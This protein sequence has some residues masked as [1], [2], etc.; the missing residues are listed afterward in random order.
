MRIPCAHV[1]P[2]SFASQ[3]FACIVFYDIFYDVYYSR[4]T[5]AVRFVTRNLFVGP[6]GTKSETLPPSLLHSGGLW[7]A[8]PFTSD[9]R[10]LTSW[11]WGLQL[12]GAIAAICSAVVFLLQTKLPLQ[13]LCKA[14]TTS[15]CGDTKSRAAPGNIFAFNRW[16]W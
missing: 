14:A 9:Q 3:S 1:S 11:T 16:V 15:S 12:R 8:E 4:R 7:A 10:T 6:V 2:S 5:I 13:S